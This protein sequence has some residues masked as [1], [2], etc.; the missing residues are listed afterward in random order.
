VI[1]PGRRE[2]QLANAKLRSSQSQKSQATA[3]QAMELQKKKE[4]LKRQM[5]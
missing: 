3:A 1:Q 5:E 4:E 2:K